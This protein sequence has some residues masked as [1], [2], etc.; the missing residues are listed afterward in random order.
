MWAERN[1]VGCQKPHNYTP[2][3]IVGMAQ[4]IPTIFIVVRDLKDRSERSEGKGVSQKAT[5]ILMQMK[6][7]FSTPDEICWSL[8]KNTVITGLNRKL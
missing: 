5:K 1:F 8:L 2:T 4:A 3:K 6:S 7:I